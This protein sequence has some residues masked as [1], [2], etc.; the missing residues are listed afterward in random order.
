MKISV[1][2]IKENDIEQIVEYFTNARPDFLIEMGADPNKLPGKEK[3]IGILQRAYRK[4]NTE[5]DF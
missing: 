1:R 4:D 5:K 2:E 3:W